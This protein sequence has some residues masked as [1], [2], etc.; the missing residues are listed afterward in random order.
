MGNEF[1]VEFKSVGLSFLMDDATGPGTRGQRRYRIRL[2]NVSGQVALS[3]LLTLQELRVLHA[4]ITD[5]L[6]RRRDQ[7]GGN[8]DGILDP[9]R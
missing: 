8:S 9:Y 5:E 1:R 7:L 2:R 3:Y 4:T 6:V